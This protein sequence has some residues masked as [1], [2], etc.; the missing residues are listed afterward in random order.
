MT[1][2]KIIILV[3][4][5]LVVLFSV[6]AAEIDSKVEKQLE[7]EDTVSVIVMLKDK[8][9]DDKEE[10]KE[11]IKEQ[12][13]KVLSKLRTGGAV[14]SAKLG[15]SSKKKKSFELTRKYTSINS[16]AGE[17]DKDSLEILKNNPNV[18]KVYLDGVVHKALDTSVPLI[19]G[20]IT[21]SLKINNTNLTGD[22]QTI[23]VIDSG[24]DTDHSAFTNKIIGQYCYCAGCCDTNTASESTSAEDDEG[25]GT[26]VA[27][28]AAGNQSPYFGVAPNAKIVAI[29]VLNDS[30]SG[31]FSDVASAIDWCVNN[32][33][34]FN[35]TIITM[36]LG[37][38]A[39]YNDPPTDCNGFATANAIDRAVAAGITVFAASGNGGNT[40]GIVYPACVSNATSVGSVTKAD[41]L[42]TS[43]DRDEILDLLAP[44]GNSGTDSCPSSTHICAAQ[45]DGTYTGLGGTSMATPHVAGAAA[46][47]QQFNNL[48][49]GT[50]LTHAGIKSIL[51]NTGDNTTGWPRIDIYEAILSLDSVAPTVTLQSPSNNTYSSN[52]NITFVYN[53]SENGLCSLYLNTSGTFGINQTNDTVVGG[54]NNFSVGFSDGT[55]WIWNVVCNDTANNTAN[56]TSNFTLTIDTTYPTIDFS[57]LTESNFSNKSQN[58]IEVNVSWTETNFQNITWD[59]NGTEYVNTTATYW[60]NETGIGDGNYTFNVTICDKAGNCNNTATRLIILDNSSPQINFST[61]SEVNNSNISRLWIYSDIT[62][63]ELYLKNVT[64]N[65]N[66]TETVYNSS[67]LN[68]NQTS[69]GNGTYY[70]NVTVCDYAGNCNTTETR[71]ILINT[72]LPPVVNNVTN[73]SI[74]S[75]GATIAWSTLDYGNL[76]V[77]YGSANNSYFNLNQTSDN[78][79]KSSS[80]SL[81]SLSA[82]TTYYYKVSSSNSY[83]ISTN[84]SVYN[85]TTSAADSGNG[86]GSGGGGGGGGSTSAATAIALTTTAT[87]YTGLKRNDKLAFV[88]GSGGHTLAISQVKNDNVEFVLQSDPVK[89]TLALGEEKKIDLGSNEQLYIKVENIQSR[90]ADIILKN[91]VKRTLPVI[92]MPVKK[93]EEPKV[94][95]EVEEEIIEEAPLPKKP[96]KEMIIG[97]GVVIMIIVLG[98]GL[99]FFIKNRESPEVSYVKRMIKRGTSE[100]E[101]K[102]AF[103]ETGWKPKKVKEIIKKIK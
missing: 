13:E 95:E 4:V 33:S 47:M 22:G 87:K 16:F 32:I 96:L 40:D 12:Q 69:L 20:T 5:F 82:S 65:I 101:V 8:P 2:K 81:S 26:H 46:L 72:S 80:I 103:K 17:V 35:I 7:E 74:S 64:W 67:T 14:A 68:H 91:I 51:I 71:E 92:P 50:N 59:I 31:A 36:S 89:F 48:Q 78:Q 29:K 99:F 44:G 54:T 100:K 102:K 86:G 55:S 27:G 38:A 76:T 73:S 62:L 30:G 41:A 77:Y 15:I 52:V 1:N 93:T 37:T 45:M 3:F 97:G 57:A 43:T 60:Y 88:S 90:K 79:V 75:S 42:W 98:L 11:M 19:N 53:T 66:G 49:N 24:I 85:F 70:Y 63:T 56:A 18:E 61:G 28:I 58:Y 21:W 94:V 23:C 10:R 6:G 83:G 39:V 25:H 34:V 9:A 84:S